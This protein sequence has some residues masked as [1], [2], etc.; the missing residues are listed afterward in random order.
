[1]TEEYGFGWIKGVTP[2]TCRKAIVCDEGVV[3]DARIIDVKNAKYRNAT[4]NGKF[5]LKKRVGDYIIP[6]AKGDC[7]QVICYWFY[8]RPETDW[9]RINIEDAEYE[10]INHYSGLVSKNIRL[11]KDGEQ[12]SPTHR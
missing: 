1:M 10:I 5:L 3:G 7:V 11:K 4:L 12:K 8:R 9:F 6:T 2:N